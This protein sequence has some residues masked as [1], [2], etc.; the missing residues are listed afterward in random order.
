MLVPVREIRATHLG[1][2]A[3]DVMQDEV[4]LV[5]LEMLSSRELA[6]LLI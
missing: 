5:V 4:T 6:F 1:I 2:D 3:G